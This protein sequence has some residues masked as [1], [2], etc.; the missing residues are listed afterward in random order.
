VAVV[1]DPGG[2]GTAERVQD[3]VRTAARA[4]EDAGCVVEEVEPP[5]IELAAKTLLDML[6]TPD[7]RAGW[8]MMSALMPADT[9]RFMSAFI[10]VAGK[11]DPVT[12]MQS[13]M[14]RQA[15]LRAWGEFQEQHPLIVAPIYTDVPFDVG[16]DLEDGRVAETIRGMRMALAVNA[17]GMPAVALP[18]GI[19]DGLPQSSR[20][21]IPASRRWYSLVPDGIDDQLDDP[22]TGRFVRCEDHVAVSV[23]MKHRGEMVRTLEQ[24]VANVIAA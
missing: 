4:L 14:T 19:R 6:N 13:F 24:N 9:Q 7:T 12:S 3:G 16:T 21:S 20:L 22:L 5:S 23:A 18:V 10:E 11:A 17:L 1:V 8:Q 15:L 2:Q